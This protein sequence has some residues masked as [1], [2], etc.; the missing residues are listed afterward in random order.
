MVRL[1]N[2]SAHNI[3]RVRFRLIHH[4]YVAS[5]IY[6]SITILQNVFIN[7]YAIHVKIHSSQHK[8]CAEPS[9]KL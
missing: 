3:K 8:L 9:T 1:V 4:V 6:V 2:V 7:V 5:E